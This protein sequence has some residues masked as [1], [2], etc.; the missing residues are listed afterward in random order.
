MEIS[1][2]IL[3]DAVLPPEVLPN[4]KNIEKAPDRQKQ[5]IA[6]D[7]ESLLIGKLLDEMGNALGDLSEES[8]AFGQVKGIFNMHLAR[9]IADKGGFGLAGQIYEQLSRLENNGS[10]QLEAIDKQI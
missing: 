7:F 10:N 3:T 6:K 1:N 8:P 2:T 5:E 9:Y 4:S